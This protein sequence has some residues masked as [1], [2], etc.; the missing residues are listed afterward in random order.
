MHIDCCHV[1]Y[2]SRQIVLKFV[3]LENLRIVSKL[4]IVD[5]EKP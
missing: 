4:A 1:R 2:K 3:L 5:G